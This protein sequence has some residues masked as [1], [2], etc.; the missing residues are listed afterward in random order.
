LLDHNISRS[1]GGEEN[2]CNGR[3]V[4]CQDAPAERVR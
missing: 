4:A 2:P 3:V 1:Y